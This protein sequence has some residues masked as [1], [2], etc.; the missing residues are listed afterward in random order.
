MLCHV[1][2]STRPPLSGAAQDDVPQYQCEPSGSGCSESSTS[3]AG[4]WSVLQVTTCCSLVGG[5]AQGGGS[6]SMTG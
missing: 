4:N 3:A 6:R 5:A 1:S 2:A